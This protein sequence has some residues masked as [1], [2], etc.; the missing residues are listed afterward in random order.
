VRRLTEKKQEAALP[1]YKP[2]VEPVRIIKTPEEIALAAQRL[3]EKKKPTLLPDM[4]APTIV[5]TKEEIAASVHRLATQRP[6]PPEKEPLPPAVVKTKEE[7]ADLL[8][9]LAP[10]ILLPQMPQKRH[11]TEDDI[12]P[13]FVSRLSVAKEPPHPETSRTSRARTVSPRFFDRLANPTQNSAPIEPCKPIGERL[14]EAT[15][16]LSQRSRKTEAEPL[17][18]GRKRAKSP[19]YVPLKASELL[20]SAGK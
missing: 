1:V 4:Q 16:H 12:V 9:R 2:S 11:F 18:E 13:S 10:P 17:L 14:A 3:S 19:I 15:K 7:I 8:R 6:N 5:K 20:F